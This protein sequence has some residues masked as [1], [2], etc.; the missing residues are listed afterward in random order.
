MSEMKKVC[1]YESFWRTI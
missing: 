1:K